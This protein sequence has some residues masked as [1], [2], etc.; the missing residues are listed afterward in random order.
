MTRTRM[1]AEEHKE[2]RRAARD[3]WRAA[4]PEKDRAAKER[5]LE[6]NRDVRNARLKEAYAEKK[7][8][9]G[10]TLK[11][12]AQTR[13]ELLR[14]KREYAREQRRTRP[15]ELAA[16]R[17]K[18]V[19]KH[20][21][22]RNAASAAWRK[23]NAGKVLALTR[24]RQLA[25]RMRTPAWLTPDDFWMM[26]QA[27]ELAALRTKMLGFAWHVDHKIPLRGKTVS[28][29]HVPTNLQVIPGADNSRKG[30]AYHG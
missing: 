3:K 17:K 9:A 26:E 27:Y 25:K 24:K 1:S 18:T 29:L 20:R 6:K 30:N 11:A 2:A 15:Q 8:A 23:K 16:I 28:G 10:P 7:Q 4:N 14:K 5:W 12:P 21:Q 19:A 13:D 22:A